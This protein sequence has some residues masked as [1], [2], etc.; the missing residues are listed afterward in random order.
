MWRQRHP[1]KMPCDIRGREQVIVPPNSHQPPETQER[2]EQ[3][4]MISGG[5]TLAWDILASKT[6]RVWISNPLVLWQLWLPWWASTTSKT[7]HTRKDITTCLLQTNHLILILLISPGGR[8][9]RWPRQFLASS[10]N[11]SHAQLF[12]DFA[13]R[14]ADLQLQ[15]ASKGPGQMSCLLGSSPCPSPCQLRVTALEVRAQHLHS[16]M[17][18]WPEACCYE[19][20]RAHSLAAPARGSLYHERKMCGC[21]AAPHVPVFV[22]ATCVARAPFPFSLQLSPLQRYS[23]ETQAVRH[24]H[25]RLLLQTTRCWMVSHW[26]VLT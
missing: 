26:E 1:L 25:L 16:V 22:S 12:Q 14:T 10:E 11:N 5:R 2:P 6:M 24:S 20:S 18:S 7:I 9:Q 4:W 8:G 21:R 19:V 3:R 15:P 23:T 13:G 17:E